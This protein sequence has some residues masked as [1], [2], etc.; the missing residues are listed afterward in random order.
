MRK[1]LIAI[2][3]SVCLL[4]GLHAELAQPTM[5][6]RSAWVIEQRR[7]APIRHNAKFGT[8]VALAR[9]ELNPNDR[10][11][12]ECITHYYDTLPEGEDGQ[13]FSY[14]G[15]A[16][17][18]GKHWDKFSPQQR[19]HLKAKL[20]GFSNLLEHGTENHAI[21]KGAAAY[22]FAQ[23]WPEETEWLQGRLSSAQLMEAARANMLAVIH[24]LYKIGYVENL[25][26]NYLPVHLFPYFALYDCAK[27]PEMKNAADAA[28]RFHLAYMAANH[29]EGI[30]IPP[31]NRDYPNTTWN[32]YTE[33]R[34]SRHASHLLHWFYWPE[35][36]NWTPATLD[37]WDGNFVVYA[38]VSEWRP[39]ESIRSIALGH[40]VPYELTSSAGGFGFWGAG[41]PAECLRYIYRDTLFAMGSG[42]FRYDPDNYYVDYTGFRLIY[43]SH[44]QYNFIEC[45]DPYWNSNDRIWKGLNSPFTQWAQHKSTAIA[46]FNIPA[47]DPWAGRG[48]ADW[49]AMRDHHFDSLIQE[50]LTRFPKSIDERVETKGWIFLREGEVYIAIRPLTAYSIDSHYEPASYDFDV[51]RCASPQTGF[52]FD[53]ASKA[54]CASFEAFQSAVLANPPTVDWD[55]LSVSYTNV[56]GDHLSA[57][58]NPPQYDAPEDERILVRPMIQV[59]GR[60]VPVDTDF[61]K[62]SA[63]IKSPPVELIEGKLRL[64]TDTP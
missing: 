36:Q 35:A 23:Y 38:A 45:Y 56:K 8:A 40:Q 3:F 55:S 48:R 1:T 34:G 37:R 62:G 42:A 43:K 59:N 18:L 9:L 19:E 6:D 50:G 20:M 26:H 53:I 31:T 60:E 24:S 33:A 57:T 4:N 15:I 14:P 28:L 21:M 5:K 25:S 30:T 2:G 52:I 63:V 58:W 12:I 7:D 27:D 49:Q 41:P 11:V 51:I 29:F 13:Q 17:I 46:L 10:E 16:W 32:T 22:L 54:T 61:I 47:K 39:P 44:D 64:D